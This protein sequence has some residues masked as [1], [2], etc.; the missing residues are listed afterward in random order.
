MP[1]TFTQLSAD[2]LTYTERPDDTVLIA[3]IPG[4]VSRAQ[5]RLARDLK[6]LGITTFVIGAFAVG[7]SVYQ[8]P[9]GWRE[10]A[11]FNWGSGTNNATRNTLLPRTLDYL[12]DFWPDPTQ[13]GTP[14]Y[15]AEYDWNHIL[16]APTPDAASPFE[17]S[18]F[19]R[20]DDLT[21][22][23]QTNWYTQ[24][25]ADMLLYACLLGTAPFI[26]NAEALGIWQAEYDRI[27]DAMKVEDTARLADEQST[28]R[29]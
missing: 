27:K 15:Y 20:S 23:N 22:E 25:A 17:W 13:T 26:K 14:L 4:I 10:T 6:V 29:T 11:R 3:A 9:T 28:G 18:Y 8:N 12:R 1:T 21:A 24:Y 5:D 7:T 19:F 16:V 2:I